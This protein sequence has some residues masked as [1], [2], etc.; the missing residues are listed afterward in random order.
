MQRRYIYICMYGNK[1]K[2]IKGKRIFQLREISSF[3]C[4]KCVVKTASLEDR[5][6]IGRHFRCVS[7]TTNGLP[8]GL[9]RIPQGTRGK[10]REKVFVT[11]SFPTELVVLTTARHFEP[12]KRTRVEG[13]VEKDRSE[14]VEGG[15]RRR[16][17][18][19]FSRRHGAEV[20]AATVIVQFAG[21][22]KYRRIL[23]K[24]R[25]G[26]GEGVA[27]LPGWHWQ[28]SE[29]P[30]DGKLETRRNTERGSLFVEDSFREDGIYFSN[31]LASRYNAVLITR[32]HECKIWYIS[33]CDGKEKR[34]KERRKES[35]RS[36]GQT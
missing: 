15:W 2:R 11:S 29:K 14:G 32:V 5:D 8:S 24:E 12:A 18:T 27:W 23:R 9:R 10:E 25:E 6:F 17:N 36:F 31:G 13:P 19:R 30:G 22:G 20:Q 7:G 34:K 35:K 4:W 33:F 28:C 26:G 21:K 16:E 3:P 1:G